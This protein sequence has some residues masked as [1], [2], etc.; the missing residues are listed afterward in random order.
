MISKT[1]PAEKA[2]IS[3][4]Q[5]LAVAVMIEQTPPQLTQGMS[6]GQAGPDFHR[7]RKTTSPWSWRGRGTNFVFKNLGNFH[8][9]KYFQIMFE[10]SQM[11]CNEANAFAI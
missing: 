3:E 9:L 1:N 7:D 6:F 11:A 5:R 2:A 4:R 8:S 10:H